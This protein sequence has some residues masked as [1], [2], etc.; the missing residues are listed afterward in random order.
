MNLWD[1]V[2][3]VAVEWCDAFAGLTCF[4]NELR[5]SPDPREEVS[6]EA[7]T[8]IGASQGF[9]VFDKHKD[10]LNDP[11]LSSHIRHLQFQLKRN[12][13]FCF[14][15]LIRELDGILHQAS[16][17]L[18]KKRFAYIPSPNDEYFE[19]DK[20]FGERVFEMFEDARQDVKDAGNC[21]AASLPTACVFH[22]MRV[23][24]HGLRALARRLKVS[25]KDKGRTVPLEYGTWDK[26]IVVCQSRITE[27]RKKSHGPK[28][29]SELSLY[30]EAAEHCAFIKDIWRNN[31]SHTRSPYSQDEASGALGRV[32][33]FMQFLAVALNKGKP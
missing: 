28:K 23:S 24:E 16:I 2:Q 11:A 12:E 6:T 30:S 26:V 19:R 18:A 22:L 3:H 21:F 25:L 33:D 7:K 15:S 8:R 31:L 9:W 5:R 1:M 4:I 20:L 27:A 13:P 17:A 32:R 14:E 29:K 10:L